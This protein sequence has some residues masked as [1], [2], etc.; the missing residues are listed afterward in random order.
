MKG[1]IPKYLVQKN[2]VVILVLGTALFAEL[3]ITIFQPFGS[4]SWLPDGPESGLVYFSLVTL[5]VLV[6]MGIIAVS[7]TLMYKLGKKREISILSYSLWIVMEV[8]A[9]AM[10]YTIA[11]M[12]VH[13]FF[14]NIV[15]EYGGFDFME[16][17]GYSFLY[18]A[19]V[20]FIPYGTFMLYFALN[21][22]NDQLQSQWRSG[23][24]EHD[25]MQMFNFC[26]EKN[27]FALSIRQDNL[28]YIM[29]A[30]NYVDIVYQSGG[31]IKHFLLRQS[32]KNIEESF[33]SRGLVRCHRSC[34]VNISKVKVLRREDDGLIV[35]F[36]NEQLQPISV[37][38]TYSTAITD[39]FT[40]M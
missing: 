37:S 35:D 31:K 13:H 12:T 28:Y 22:R 5:V 38:K 26:D 30:D 39:M 18:T 21:D 19:F 23:Q 3:F 32:L 4:R 9:M 8:I 36:D 16:I 1:N 2:N 29:A 6:A 20:L 14:P 25:A 7:R 17:L 40:T 27:D 11:V 15:R 33:A 10:T 24:D 34:V